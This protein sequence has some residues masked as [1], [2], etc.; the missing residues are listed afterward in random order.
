MASLNTCDEFSELF[1]LTSETLWLSGDHTSCCGLLTAVRAEALSCGAFAEVI[2]APAEKIVTIGVGVPGSPGAVEVGCDSDE[3]VTSGVT[4]GSEQP[5]M[6]SIKRIERLVRGIVFTL[7][8]LSD[9]SI[10]HGVLY[11]PL[12]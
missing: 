3:G 1:W 7:R 8:A 9:V 12:S 6:I 10:R 11:T 4:L 2:G 5:A